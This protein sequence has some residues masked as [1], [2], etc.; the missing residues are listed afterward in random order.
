MS[1]PINAKNLKGKQKAS[2]RNGGTMDKRTRDT[3]TKKEDVTLSILS[4]RE[5]DLSLI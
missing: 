5:V 2:Q 3:M 4:S 1:F